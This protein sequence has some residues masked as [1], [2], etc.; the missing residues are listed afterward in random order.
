M[1]EMLTKL[2]GVP[3]KR[4]TCGKRSRTTS[5]GLAINWEDKLGTEGVR[6]K[7]VYIPALSTHVKAAWMWPTDYSVPY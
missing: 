6:E 3:D 2:V 4:T 1:R 7:W 5:V